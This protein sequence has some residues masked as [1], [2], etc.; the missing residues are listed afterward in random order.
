MKP[1][2]LILLSGL[3]SLLG[4]CASVQPFPVPKTNPA[5]A[6]VRSDITAHSGQTVTW[7]GVILRTEVRQNDSLVMVLAKPLDENGEPVATDKSY[8]RF[9]ARF[10]GFR[11]PAIFAAGRELTVAGIIR[12]GESR[13]IGEYEYLYPLVAVSQYRLWPVPVSYRDDRDYWWYEPW[14]PWYPWYPGYY[15]P[16]VYRPAPQK[17]P[18]K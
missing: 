7:G 1:V 5:L 9:L 18:P 10:H 14:Y 12:G 13:K 15:S 8:G 17:L 2:N 11:D 16:P 3:F 4:A 6:G